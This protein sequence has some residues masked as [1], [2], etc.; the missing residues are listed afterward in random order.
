MSK[1]QNFSQ[2]QT[3]A[4]HPPRRKGPGGPMGGRG[5]MPGEKPKDLK[6]SLASLMRYMGRY[7]FGIFAVMIF[8]ACSTVF[9]VIGPKILGS[10][11]TELYNGLLAK[12]QGSGAIDFGSCWDCIFAVRCSASCRAGL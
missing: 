6:K 5:M 2:E 9:S 10:A 3:N 4:Y 11:T 12:I 1:Q 7:K 8:A